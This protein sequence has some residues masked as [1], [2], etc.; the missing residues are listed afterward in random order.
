MFTIPAIPGWYAGLNKPLFTPPDAVFAPVWTLL[1]LLMGIAL[2]LVWIRTDHPDAPF[3]L[4]WFAIQ[5]L[6][7]VSWSAVFFG[8]ESPGLGLIVIL[9]LW[10]AIARTLCGSAGCR[11]RP[12]G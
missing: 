11:R 10:V 6:L 12:H 8:L 3:A 1:F 2:A 9:L 7:N 5:W 4:R